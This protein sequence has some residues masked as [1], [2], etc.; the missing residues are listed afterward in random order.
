MIASFSEEK[1]QESRIISMW[2][3]T[4]SNIPTGWVVCDGNNK[5]PDLTGKFVKGVSNSSE[6]PGS[7]S[8]QDSYSI[9]ESQLPSHRHTGSTTQDGKHYH[10]IKHSTDDNSGASFSYITEVASRGSDA[11]A[12]SDTD[13]GGGHSHNWS[14]NNSGSGNSIDNKP[15]FYEVAFIMKS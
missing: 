4:I 8:G 7:V 15:Q 3:G 9:S 14:V 1:E 12:Y 10:D 6:I 13:T 2:S 5:T 11:D